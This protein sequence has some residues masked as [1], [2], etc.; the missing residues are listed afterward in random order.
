MELKRLFDALDDKV[1]GQWTAFL[2]ADHGGA[3]VPSH[4][5]AEGCLSITGNR[6]TSW[7]P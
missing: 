4:A 1:K 3:N 2:S 5:S 7:T 6:A